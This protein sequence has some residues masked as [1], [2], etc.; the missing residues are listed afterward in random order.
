MNQLRF[1]EM[2]ESAAGINEPARVRFQQLALTQ[3]YLGRSPGHS[4]PIWT[5]HCLLRKESIMRFLAYLSTFS[6]VIS[7][8]FFALYA[9]RMAASSK[10]GKHLFRPE[11]GYNPFYSFYRPGLL[12][13]EGQAYRTRAG[14][15][16]LAFVA[17]L[18]VTIL[19][20]SS[21]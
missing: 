10:D 5:N 2:A 17:S 21:I 4:L 16:F 15:S 11:V 18:A 20:W 6:A 12:S 7:F 1:G 13:P 9:G 14:Y 19:L 8:V 3:S